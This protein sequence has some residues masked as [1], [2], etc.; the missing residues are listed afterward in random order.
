MAK[1][2]GSKNKS[3]ER[4]V[5]YYKVTCKCDDTDEP[6]NNLFD[7]YIK[8]YDNNGNNLEGRGL[9]IPFY[10]KFHFLE[11]FQHKHDKDYQGR[12]YSLRDTDFPYLFNLLNGYRQEIP[13]S[14]YD[15]LMEQTHFCYIVNKN[16]LVSEYNFHGARI[17]RLANYLVSIMGQLQPSKNY[18][19]SIDPIIMPDY[20]TR[21]A[22]CRSLS[23]LQFKVAKPGLK[24]L[25]EFGIINGYDILADEV[26]TEADFY[27]NIE[28]YGR[29]K[30]GYVPFFN[31]Q[32]QK[33]FLQKIIKMIKRSKKIESESEDGSNPIFSKAKLRGLDSDTGKIILYD[34]LEE[35][36]VQNELVEKVSERSKYVDSEKMFTA[37]LK[38]YREQ[39][40]TALKYMEKK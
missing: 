2:N 13:A 28:V 6:I 35:K 17:E 32:A 3:V 39:K 24:M 37:I 16:L 30:G 20:Y 12:F 21:I 5:Y 18:E 31:L 26:D 9:A 34:L 14:Y 33:E 1:K 38:A 8:L 27:I 15:T 36:L 29:R 11:V 22:N 4:K 19:V 25:K 23:K 10:D 40:D 7:A